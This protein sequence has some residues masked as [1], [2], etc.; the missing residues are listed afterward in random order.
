MN[1]FYYFPPP[2]IFNWGRKIFHSNFTFFFGFC[3]ALNLPI[4]QKVAKIQKYGRGRIR[5]ANL[6]RGSRTHTARYQK[7]VFLGFLGFKL[8]D[9][10]IGIQGFFKR[11]LGFSINFRMKL[12]GR[13]ENI[14]VLAGR[15]VIFRPNKYGEENLSFKFY[16][17]FLFFA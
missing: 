2:S 11:F 3:F 6:W 15:L 4:A 10:Y 16:L 7:Q 5:T 8:Q 1:T 12:R 9:F 14:P 13:A 17:F